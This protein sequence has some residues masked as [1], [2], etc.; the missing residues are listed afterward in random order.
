MIT[1][2]LSFLFACGLRTDDAGC[3]SIA[4]T[5]GTFS[6]FLRLIHRAFSGKKDEYLHVCELLTGSN[7]HI[8][9]KKRHEQNDTGKTIRKKRSV[10][11][12]KALQTWADAS[13][14]VILPPT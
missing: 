13:E 8:M 10:A 4:I 11:A 12:D 5:P 2:Q 14:S 1:A 9:V 7:Q 6:S 3:D